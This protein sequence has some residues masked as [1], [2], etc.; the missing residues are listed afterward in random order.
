MHAYFKLDRPLE[1][2]RLNEVRVMG[3]P[4]IELTKVDDQEGLVF[5][6][7]VDEKGVRHGR[8]VE[9]DDT[10]KIFTNP[11]EKRTEDYITGRFG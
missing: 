8:L 3:Q 7:E 1:A 4:D 5:T 6:A 11:K 2:V 10:P 9:Y